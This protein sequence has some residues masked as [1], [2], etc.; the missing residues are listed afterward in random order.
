MGTDRVLLFVS[1]KQSDDTMN[2]NK[3]TRLGHIAETKLWNKKLSQGTIDSSVNSWCPR[4]WGS[5]KEGLDMKL[6]PTDRRKHLALL[7]GFHFSR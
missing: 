3:E 7:I 6:H 5:D 4:W 1:N 2:K